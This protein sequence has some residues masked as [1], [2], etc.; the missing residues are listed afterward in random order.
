MESFRELNDSTKKKNIPL[1]IVSPDAARGSIIFSSM[2][3]TDVGIISCDNTAV[4]TAAR[5]D[6]TIFLL[7]KGTII[8]KQSH[9]RLRKILAAL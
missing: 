1:F 7:K 6:P 2:H 3:Y 9:R 4:R 5:A 8:E